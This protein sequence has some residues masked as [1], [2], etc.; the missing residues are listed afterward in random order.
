MA[1]PNPAPSFQYAEA[2][3]SFYERADE[4]ETYPKP[5]AVETAPPTPV[6]EFGYMLPQ[7]SADAPA[8]GQS[9]SAQSTEETG[10]ASY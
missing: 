6:L 7:Q 9:P 4:S 2:E 5:P 1:V 8:R 3:V 10:D